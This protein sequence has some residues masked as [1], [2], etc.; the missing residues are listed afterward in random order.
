MCLMLF[1]AYYKDLVII[2]RFC[3]FVVMHRL[4]SLLDYRFATDGHCHFDRHVITGIGLCIG[5]CV[6]IP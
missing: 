3:L 4:L 5:A 6:A 1:T 2:R